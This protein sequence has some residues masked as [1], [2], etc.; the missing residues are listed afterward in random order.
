MKRAILIFIVCLIF[1]TSPNI[2]SQIKLNGALQSSIYAWEN[3]N[4]NQ[5]WDFYQGLQLRLTPEKYSNLSFNTYLRAAYRGDPAEWKEKVWNM[6]VKWKLGKKYKLY[7]GRQFLYSGVING[8]MDAVLLS[9]KFY[10]NFQLRAVVGVEA[11]EQR[12]LKIRH[13]DNG[14]VIG[15][16]LAYSM[17]WQNSLEVSYFQKER[18]SEKY[19]QQAGTTFRG[20]LKEKLN[21]YARLDYNMKSSA[22]QAMRFRLTYFAGLWSLS[23]E[24]NS[25]KPRIY[26]DSFFNIFDV[27]AY[28][29]IRTAATY[30]LGAYN[31][32]LQYLHTKYQH[33]NDSRVVGSVDTKY[34]MV[35]IIYQTGYGGDNMG[36]FFDLRYEFKPNLTA[37]LYNS[38]Y[39][40]E[41]ALTNISDD[42]L[43]FI[44]GLGY[45][46]R[47]QVL[48]QG[49]LQQ[50]S[51]K[52]YKS[53]FRGLMRLTYL[54]N[55]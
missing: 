17:P 42:A 43:A 4:E 30:R 7:V 35:G 40:Y 52:Y 54:F 55:L 5:Q 18:W 20:Y 1:F 27:K 34:G 33:D 15:G 38:Y 53:D 12:E 39:K 21:Y 29:Q 36:Y 11:N 49:E 32:G 22:Y 46:W 23:G 2:Y 26:E 13:W 6:Y 10:K 37:R 9:A 47:N 19:W 48:I 45:R 3:A 16:Y 51:N 28:N 50:S 41:R 8:T 31:L 44:A 24:Y 14:N 25:Q